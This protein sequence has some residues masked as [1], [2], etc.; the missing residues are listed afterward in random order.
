[1]SADIWVFL[2]VSPID[3]LLY[4]GI[5]KHSYKVCFDKIALA[6]DWNF[7][8]FVSKIPNNDKATITI[9]LSL[10]S[11]FMLHNYTLH[12]IRAF[13]H[14][15]HPNMWVWE[16]CCNLRAEWYM[17]SESHQTNH[18]LSHGIHEVGQVPDGWGPYFPSSDLPYS[19]MEEQSVS[20]T[21]TCFLLFYFF[22]YWKMLFFCVQDRDLT[23]IILSL[24]R[25]A[26]RK[27]QQSY[28]RLDCNIHFITQQLPNTPGWRGVFDVW[29]C[30]HQSCRRNPEIPEKNC[31]REYGLGNHLHI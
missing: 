5:W 21:G 28:Q 29:T 10:M 9:R 3:L 6:K 7:F 23:I 2:L 27:A 19:S 26:V 24:H 4:E 18:R 16:H 12:L 13:P 22:R 14:V 25:H 11:N 1:M 20:Q 31:E 30:T 15:L 17:A 8:N